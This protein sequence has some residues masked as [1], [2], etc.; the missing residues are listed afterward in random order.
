MVTIIVLIGNASN[1]PSTIALI[2]SSSFG[3]RA[4]FGGMLGA[5]FFYPPS[6]RFTSTI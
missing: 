3:P 2:F 1:I 6:R 4:A 5:A